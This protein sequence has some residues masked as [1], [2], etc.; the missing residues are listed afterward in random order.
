MS[1]LDRKPII[2]YR[3]YI[4]ISVLASLLCYVN[5]LYRERPVY[6]L[7]MTYAVVLTLCRRL[8]TNFLS[9]AVIIINSV[10][11]VRYAVYPVSLVLSD[12]FYFS[13]EALYLMIY[14]LVVVLLFL[15]F[16]S[17][18]LNNLGEKSME[19]IKCNDLG[20]LNTGLI[21][22]TFALGVIF[23]SLSSV[24][25]HLS[26]EA[27]SVSGVIS[28]TFS[29]GLIIIYTSILSKIG[30]W[31]NGKVVSLLLSI[32]WAFLYIF[33]SSVG[34]T[35]VHRWRFLTIGIPTTYVLLY[36]FP[37]YRNGIKLI[38]FM[39]FPIVIF[40]GTFAKFAISDMSIV[41]FGN[42]FITSESLSAYFGGLYDITSALAVLRGKASAESF[43]CTLTDFFGNMPV[44]SSFF[45][46]Q[47]LSTEAI[48]LDGI[49][50]KD[51]I[52]PL[53]A[54]SVIHFGVI[55]APIL[56][57]L[58]TI[59]AVE[60]ERFSRKAK[61]VYSLYGGVMLC[62][63]FSIF[64]C[65][66]TTILMPNLWELLIFIVLQ[67]INEKYFLHGKVVYNCTNI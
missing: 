49:G 45:N 32:L 62:V 26:G 1:N 47:E 28:V 12:D 35:N 37:H 33:L 11:L 38:S 66:N 51:L 34:E 27:V 41:S 9:L 3:V 59:I 57:I 18:R 54:Q 17:T 58:M 19:I 29:I 31:K 61:T 64:M 25:V 43:M 20:T 5:S 63:T 2:I 4:F 13:N 53:L 46:A 16:Y 40:I 6:L 55:G 67:L 8:R 24:F 39:V 14:E 44:I 42:F 30:N 60:A 7:P 52:C 65:V 10:C 50:R 23:P 22:I 36:S 15:N 21:F 48:Y 56:S